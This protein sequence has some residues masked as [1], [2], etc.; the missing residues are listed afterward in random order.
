MSL[1]LLSPFSKTRRRE[2]IRLANEEFFL[3]MTEKDPLIRLLEFNDFIISY[4]VSYVAVLLVV[5]TVLGNA[6]ILF[7]L[8]SIVVNKNF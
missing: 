8:I 7:V 6:G 3:N 4:K 1:K 2:L 5:L